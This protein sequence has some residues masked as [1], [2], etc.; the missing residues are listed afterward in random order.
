M[1]IFL[2]FLRNTAHFL[3]INKFSKINNTIN[4]NLGKKILVTVILIV[5]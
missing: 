3:K 5:L 1:I 2:F 4:N